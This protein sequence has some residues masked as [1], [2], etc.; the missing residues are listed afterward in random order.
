MIREDGGAVVA[1]IIAG[2]K[3]LVIW[4][5]LRPSPAWKFPGGR[6]ESREDKEVAVVRETF[7][8][9]G[10]QIPLRRGIDERWILGDEKIRLV[11]QSVRSCP[12][13]GGGSHR[14]YFFVFH[15]SE[16]EVLHLGN[17]KNKKEDT[18]DLIDTSVL[19]LD[20]L[21]TMPDFLCWQ[22]P[23]LDQVLALRPV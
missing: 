22:R 11:H 9:T 21:A 5:K 2:N 13:K 19:D 15:A 14:Q 6:I 12:S 8:E 3:A 18:D 16:S 10:F 4:Q 7:D 17:Q 1:A 23:L 20:V